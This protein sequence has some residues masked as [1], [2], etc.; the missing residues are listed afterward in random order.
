[1]L[2][3]D[4]RRAPLLPIASELQGRYSSLPSAGGFQQSQI[5]GLTDSD[6]EVFVSADAGFD[7]PSLIKAF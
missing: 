7:Q 2:L 5:T 3:N 6:Q 1:M 4:T